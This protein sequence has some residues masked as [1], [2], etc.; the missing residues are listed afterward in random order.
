[1][2][3]MTFSKTFSKKT[4]KLSWQEGSKEG[5]WLQMNFERQKGIR[6]SSLGAGVG[7]PSKESEL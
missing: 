3:E 7:A 5:T 4:P 6:L 1:M 2:G